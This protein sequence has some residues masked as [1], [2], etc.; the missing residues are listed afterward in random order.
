MK[1]WITKEGK[2]IP[3]NNLSDKHLLNI[4]KM[5]K[6]T[7]KYRFEHQNPNK[8]VTIASASDCIPEQSYEI[9]EHPMLGDL[10]F[11]AKLRRL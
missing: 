4:I 10:I 8:F 5:L 1:N 2:A 9:F 6:R 11:E 7:Q 3:I